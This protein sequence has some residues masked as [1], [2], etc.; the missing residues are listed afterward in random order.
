M[1]LIMRKAV[2]PRTLLVIALAVIV[3]AC[4][5]LTGS[6]GGE[7]ELYFTILHTNDEHSNLLPDPLLDYH[8]EESNP[9]R[10]GFARVAAA[11]KEIR[12]LKDEEDEPV[13]LISGGD[14]LGGSPYAWLAL[15]GY[16]AELSLMIELGYDIV[17][18]GNHEFDFGDDVLAAYLQAAG[19]PAAAEK[20]AVVSS[21]IHPHPGHPLGNM[22]IRDTYIRKLDNGLTLG[23][24]GI[25]GIDA[26][27]MAPFAEDVK[28]ADPHTAAAEAVA[29]LRNAG[30]DLVVAVTHMGIDEEQE[31]AREVDGIDII[32]G[33]HSHT[34][35]HEP[36]IEGDT[37]IVQSGS[38]FR[39]LGIVEFAYDPVSDKL[40]VRNPETGR[41]HL[42]PI[43]N[44]IT[45]DPEFEAKLAEYTGRLNDLISRMTDGRFTDISEIIV[46][47]D[48][49]LPIYNGREAPMGN[50]VTDAMRIAA[51]E[52]LGEKVHFAFQA[53]GP[54]RGGIV[55]SAMPY[56]KGAVSFYDLAKLV[57]LG[58]GVDNTPGFPIVSAYFTAPEVKK[59]MEI[60]VF[61]TQYMGGDYFLQSSGLRAVYD[62]DRA[63]VN[64][65]VIDQLAP[66][67]FGVLSLDLFTGDGIQ[68]EDTEEYVP[69]NRA[70]EKL[71]HVATDYSI[72]TA[73]PLV[74]EEVPYLLLKPKDKDGNP[75]DLQ[76]Q[77]VMQNGRELKMW[78]AVMEHAARQPLDAEGNP[79]IAEVYSGTTGRLVESRGT[80]LWIWPAVVLALLAGL[81]VLTARARK[82]KRAAT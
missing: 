53:S 27:L 9:S 46:Y 17:T 67:T 76:E 10:G 56:S 72:A 31:M 58:S 7:P 35:L 57:G 54:I 69:L 13:L 52:A 51:E 81:V 70:G 62:M 22:G 3:S 44:T 5:N 12:A 60:S 79:R 33:G 71:Y 68:G 65:P 61:L 15:D 48:F 29:S 8:P 40:R 39:N 16:A 41:P 20:T 80:P 37:I 26:I 55:P 24:F 74:G 21:N 59:I 42:L 63:A 77:V 28:F 4:V 6:I 45:A 36:V 82:K 66:T 2:W 11:V 78:Q 25:I 30:V 47:T 14:Y 75:V 1:R 19:Y 34:N 18:I 73:I 23:F 49:E 64:V 50:F 38:L 32:V 43:D